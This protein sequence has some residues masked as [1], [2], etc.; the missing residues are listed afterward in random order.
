M[1]ARLHDVD[2]EHDN[3]RIIVV[4]AAAQFLSEVSETG[5]LPDRVSIFTGHSEQG[6]PIFLVLSQTSLPTCVSV[7]LSYICPNS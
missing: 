1:E 3:S 5:E 6:S 2:L 7:R 4:E